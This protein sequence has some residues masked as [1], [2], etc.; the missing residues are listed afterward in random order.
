MDCET[1]RW[2]GSVGSRMA[3]EEC[4]RVMIGSV[5]KWRGVVSQ[6]LDVLRNGVV[7]FRSALLRQGRVLDSYEWLWKGEVEYSNAT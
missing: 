7:L 5:W 3:K 2:P 6:G 1:K 4:R